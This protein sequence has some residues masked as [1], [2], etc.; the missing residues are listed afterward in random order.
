MRKQN[1]LVIGVSNLEFVNILLTYY[2][3]GLK[4]T[5]DIY[6]FI[7]DK[8]VTINQIKEV[9]SNHNV[10]IFNNATYI[11]TNDVYDHYAQ[12]HCYEGKA[13]DMLYNQYIHQMM[14]FLFLMI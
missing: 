9:I 11:I 1:A 4:E 13:K 8:K 6:L 3:K 10:N 5:F 14:M 2:P 12:K 7:D